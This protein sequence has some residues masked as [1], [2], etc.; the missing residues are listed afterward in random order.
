MVVCLN[1]GSEI[2]EGFRFCPAC[3]TLA[4]A[5]AQ[6]AETLI[7]RTLNDKY[8]ILSE[9]GAG[10]TGRVYLAEH[11]GLKKRV[12]LKVLHH[13][14]HV[15]EDALHRF[16]REGMVAGQFNHPNAIQIFDFDKS[17]SG[18]FFLAMEYVEGVS[19]RKL[20]QDSGPLPPAEAVAIITQAL[21]ALEEAHRQGIIHRDL[22][23]DNIMVVE[24]RDGGRTVKILD[25]GLSKLIDRPL[26]ESARTQTG[27]IVGT[28]LYMAPE[29]CAGASLDL[30]TDV[31]AAG[32]IL[33]EMLCGEL[34]FR[35]ATVSEILLERTTEGAAPLA[36]AHPHLKIPA[37]LD[38]IVGRA[39]ERAPEDRFQSAQ[40]M[41]QALGEIDFERMASPGRAASQAR[42]R[43][44]EG[45]AARAARARPGQQAVPGQRRGK[46]L[47]IGAAAVVV[48]GLA[49]V[50]VVQLS[51]GRLFGGPALPRASMKE[52]AR[53]TE[54]EKRYV[55]FLAEAQTALRFRETGAALA[56]VEQALAM[57]CRDSEA[58]LVRGSVHRE[59]GDPDSDML[60]LEE[61]LRQDLEY[62]AAAAGKGFVLLERG[63]A[64]EALARFQEA[65]RLDTSSGAALA[66]QGAALRLL[67]E[68]A[69]A[70][71]ALKRAIALDPG[72]ALAHYHLGRLLLDRGDVAG[73]LSALL[74]A[75]RED[76][77]HW[78]TCAALG[79]AHA[80]EDRLAEAETS[81]L[82]ALKI[83]PDALEPLTLLTSILIDQDRCAEALSLLAP[84]ARRHP[85]EGGVHI[86]LGA[87]LQAEGRTEEAIQALERGTRLKGSDLQAKVLL[88][89]LLQRAGRLD[90]A[91]EQYQNVLNVGYESAAARLNL[92]LALFGQER[93]GEAAA[94]IARALEIEPDN[95]FA[96]RALGILYMDYVGGN[97]L[98]AR[99]L[100]R[101]Q[102][103]G[104][105]DARL[106]E[107]LRKVGG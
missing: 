63:E 30:R 64:Q 57:E 89:I 37:D 101:Y 33:Y 16:Q 52:E 17:A 46:L 61:A 44:L 6:A 50:A 5:S 34:P 70:E 11:I 65:A 13:D 91:I 99:H 42:T 29:Q 73:A 48:L 104:G 41:A 25:F 62:A 26:A 12:A 98:A 94:E 68:D 95:A 72:S 75:R 103:L 43:R 96:H 60:D 85:E 80:Q 2:K 38:Q 28:P 36:G 35:S 15:S 97:E 7:G 87:C 4:P 20:M 55:G 14:L 105:K 56:A 53:R 102:E 81:L 92:G 59:R 10:S 67:G 83:E 27:A 3:G 51:S 74:R 24:G 84:P 82:E 40:D 19:L 100:R 45:G 49:T 69:A 54:A 78:P 107:W 8:R 18:T 1:C 32:L 88:G 76:A 93:Y 22:K 86:L 23:P 21:G 71:D 47:L 79:E 66:G 31:Y 58:Y 39:L 106:P 77:R 9:L 90:E